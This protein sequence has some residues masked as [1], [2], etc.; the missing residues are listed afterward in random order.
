MCRLSCNVAASASASWNLHGLPS[1]VRIAFLTFHIGNRSSI[2][3][4]RTRHSVVIR[5]PLNMD[6]VHHSAENLYVDY[7]KSFSVSISSLFEPNN[8]RRLVHSKIR[9]IPLYPSISRMFNIFP[10]L[11][12]CFFVAQAIPPEMA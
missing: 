8:L 12:S 10:I 3:S 9:W 5:T 6:C 2:R 7:L 11:K 1:P 4:L